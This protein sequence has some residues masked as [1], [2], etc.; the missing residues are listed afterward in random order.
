[1]AKKNYL[2]RVTAAALAVMAMGVFGCGLHQRQIQWQKVDDSRDGRAVL[3]QPGWVRL[4]F[5]GFQM[6]GWGPNGWE[7]GSDYFSV[8]EW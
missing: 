3:R 4:K 1:M 6:T 5:I 8:P 2:K 7:K